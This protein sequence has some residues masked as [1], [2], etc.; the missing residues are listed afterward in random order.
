MTVDANKAKE[1]HSLGAH[2]DG[3][4]ILSVGRKD[5]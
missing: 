3:V 1:C 2:R 5:F 4:V